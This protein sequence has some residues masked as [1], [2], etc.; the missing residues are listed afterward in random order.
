LNAATFA[1][2][3]ARK[4]HAISFVDDLVKKAKAETPAPKPKKS[5]NLKASLPGALQ[6]RKA[7]DK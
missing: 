5:R 4:W 3:T 1:A 2:A 7:E 6:L